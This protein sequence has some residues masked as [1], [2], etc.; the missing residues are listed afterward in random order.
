MDTITLQKNMEIED[1]TQKK[2]VSNIEKQES[3]ISVVP[4]VKASP[5]TRKLARELAVDIS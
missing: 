4:K 5:A 1:T 3:F 2:T